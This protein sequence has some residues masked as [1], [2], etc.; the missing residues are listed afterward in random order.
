MYQTGVGAMLMY[1]LKVLGYYKHVKIDSIFV[2][3]VWASYSRAVILLDIR[4]FAPLLVISLR[5]K[6]FSQM[7]RETSS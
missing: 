6:T 7:V 2:D 1:R 4:L 5:V 3:I